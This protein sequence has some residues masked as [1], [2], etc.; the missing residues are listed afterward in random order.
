MSN[1]QPRWSRELDAVIY[2]TPA[3]A[4]KL[5][6][7]AAGESPTVYGL[8]AAT[9]EPRWTCRLGARMGSG[10]AI[11]GDTAYLPSYDHQ[12]YAPDTRTGEPRWTF[13][14][15]TILDSSRW[16]STAWLYQKL[17]NDAV[18]A[19]DARTDRSGGGPRRCWSRCRTRPPPGRRSGWSASG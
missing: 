18:V 1:G 19:L 13:A 8:D 2:A 6:I 16:W 3:V 7:V 17:T 10:M 14:A 5:V 11:D 9:G 12:L 4:G 15:E